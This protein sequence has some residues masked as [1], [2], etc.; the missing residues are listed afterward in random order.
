MQVLAV[1]RAVAARQLEWFDLNCANGPI[2][3]LGRQTARWESMP[4]CARVQSSSGSGFNHRQ[5][6]ALACIIAHLR[7]G[8]GGIKRRLRFDW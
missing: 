6:V 4:R 5:I 2:A 3:E 1:K 8:A 7:P